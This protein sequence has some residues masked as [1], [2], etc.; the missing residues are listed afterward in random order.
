VSWALHRAPPSGSIPAVVKRGGSAMNLPIVLPTGW[1][2]KAD[3]SKRVGTWP[4]RGMALGGLSLEEL[5]DE[6]RTQLGIAKDRMALRAKGV[7]QFGK[8]AAA[9]NAGF[10]KGDIITEIDGSSARATESE[11][12]GRLLKNRKVG[13][14]VKTKVQ[15]GG[16]SVELSLPMQ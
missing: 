16:S 8:H 9:K 6:E 10:Q 5:P 2:E 3:I 7:G 4:M 11:L 14:R 13:E 1:R 12:I 15:R